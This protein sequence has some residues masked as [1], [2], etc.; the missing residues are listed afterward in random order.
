MTQTNARGAARGR[1]SV[2]ITRV[3]G[4]IEDWGVVSHRTWWRAVLYT[5]THPVIVSNRLRWRTRQWLRSSLT[6]A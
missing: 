4:D 5:L 6:P 2:V 3:N 1:V